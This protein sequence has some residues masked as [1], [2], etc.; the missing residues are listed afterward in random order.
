MVFLFRATQR[1]AVSSDSDLYRLCCVGVAIA[2][3]QEVL[4]LAAASMDE[5][6]KVTP[7]SLFHVERFWV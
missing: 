1:H 5:M 4:V 2:V 3:C 7:S 6:I